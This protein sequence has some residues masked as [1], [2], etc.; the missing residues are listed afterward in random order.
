M[1]DFYEE[2][3]DFANEILAPTS[4]GGLGQG[5]ITLTRT[6]PG[7]P[8]EDE[9]WVPVEPTEQS[10]TLDGAVSGV[11]SRLVGTEAGSAVIRAS[12][13]QCIATVP[14]TGYQAG[15]VLS[16]DGQAVNIL[17]VTKIPAAGTTAAVKFLIRG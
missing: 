11:D 5:V 10:E 6:T 3:R 12:D 7:V 16:I 9:P 13:R 2:L 14:S 15:D 8:D 17:S 4:D 1:S